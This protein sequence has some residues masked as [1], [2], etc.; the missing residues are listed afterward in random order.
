M[1]SWSLLAIVLLAGAPLAW[2]Q[3]DG[4]EAPL[5]RVQ[6]IPLPG[7]EG[8][9][10]H[11]A[12]DVKGRRL[13]VAALGNDTLEVIDLRT[14]KV[15]RSVGGLQE[16]QGVA[17]AADLGRVFV[18]NGE[19]GTCAVLDAS[20]LQ[21]AGSV[22]GL[23]DADNVRYDAAAREVFVG[24]GRGAL[25]VLGA[26]TGKHLAGI[27]LAG[28]PESFQLEPSGSR[29][30]V[31]VPSAGQIAVVDRKKREVVGAWPVQG[32]GANFPMA[33]DE[34]DHRLF[35]GCRRPARLLVYDTGTGKQVSSAEIAGDTDDLFYDGARK[36]LYVAGG[37][38]SITVLE[39]RD[40]DHY[41]TLARL[42]TAPGAR[43][44]LF[45]PELDRFYLAV[46]HRG[47]QGAEVRVYAPGS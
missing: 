41:A 5:K 36:R 31:N 39:Q 30:F 25:A 8:R 47:S 19:G 40:A 37:E 3:C 15:A 45:V 26:A 10:D 6:T 13:F 38:G 23:D 22:P 46:P 18:G 32:A 9:F 2:R 12:A 29:I 42:P 11:C 1:K 17:F 14:G 20:N 43:T 4:E 7:V 24:Y 44:A 16:P 34:A 27:R 28:H 21:P 35:I 33:L